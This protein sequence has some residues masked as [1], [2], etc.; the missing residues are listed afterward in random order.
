MSEMFQLQ[1]ETPATTAQEE[2]GLDLLQGQEIA[3]PQ[4]MAQLAAVLD[5]QAWPLKAVTLGPH[6]SVI[7]PETAPPDSQSLEAFARAQGLDDTAV[8]WLFGGLAGAMPAAPS[9]Q[10]SGANALTTGSAIGALGNVSAAQVASQAATQIGTQIAAPAASQPGAQIGAQASALAA[11]AAT[12][13]AQTSEAGLPSPT[14]NATTNSSTA[15]TSAM[16]GSMAVQTSAQGST[17]TGQANAANN[18]PTTGPATGL[19]GSAL[20]GAQALWAMADDTGQTPKTNAINSTSTE[21]ALPI[22]MLRMPPPA[23]VWMQRSQMNNVL[24]SS[25]SA[26]KEAAIS[27]SELDLGADWGGETLQQ[28]LGAEGGASNTGTHGAAYANFASRWDAQANN[29]TDLNNANGPA[30]DL[31]DANARS[32]N[33]QNLAEKMGQAVGQRILSEMEKGQWHLKLQLRPATLGHIE[34]EMRMRSGE[35]DAVFTAPNGTTRE[36][37]QEGMS[38]LRETLSQMGMDVANIHVGGGQTGQ[39]GGEST[40][41]FTRG[42]PAQAQTSAPASTAEITRAPRVKDPNDGLDV[43]V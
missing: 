25:V 26:Q 10:L 12:D 4:T 37:L 40:P 6:L 32:E 29:R 39:S 22:Q 36:L 17:P 11:N 35:F 20:A 7:T 42:K 13:N 1:A 23:A 2:A 19:L 43:L 38:K 5:T 18:G 3:A 41:G 24:Q 31:P 30:P 15:A 28:L 33:I 16:Q 9:P 14:N 34:V 8:N 27:L 21:D